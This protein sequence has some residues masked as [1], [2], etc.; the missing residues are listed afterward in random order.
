MCSELSCSNPAMH[1]LH[2]LHPLLLLHLLHPLLLL[3]LLHP[4]HPLHP[5][6]L[7]YLKMLLVGINVFAAHLLQPPPGPQIAF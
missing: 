2:F 1:P 5:L 4:L 3:H 7:L 6:H